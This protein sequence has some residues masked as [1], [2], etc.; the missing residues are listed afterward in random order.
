VST[1]PPIGKTPEVRKLGASD[2]IN[3]KILR[4]EMTIAE[5]VA[6]GAV[7]E[8][9]VRSFQ[10]HYLVTASSEKP[11]DEI[12]P[13]LWRYMTRGPLKYI[14]VPAFL[15]LII[16]PAVGGLYESGARLYA[17]LATSI[18]SLHEKLAEMDADELDVCNEW[19]AR[20]GRFDTREDA[21][22]AKD[23]LI[24]AMKASNEWLWV[25]DV[26][27]ARDPQSTGAFLLTVDMFD[28]A[29]SQSEVAKEINRLQNLTDYEARNK[30]GNKMQ[31]AV[32]FYYRLSE[33]QRLYGRLSPSV[34]HCFLNEE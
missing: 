33:F 29:S 14:T 10:Q 27:I 28:A 32:A 1:Q 6:S 18:A 13:R 34:Q 23:E 24:Q 21:R 30:I 22:R 16:I 20:I 12:I 4:G 19:V 7:T 5:A 9:Q 25:D 15:I 2:E 31:S 3:L 17:A 8:Q 26:H 11:W